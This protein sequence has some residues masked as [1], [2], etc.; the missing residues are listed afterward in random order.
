MEENV[1]KDFET[2]SEFPDKYLKVS[3]NS[4]YYFIKKSGENFVAKRSLDS[5][6][7]VN[8]FNKDKLLTKKSYYDVSTGS[9]ILKTVSIKD[10]DGNN[11]EFV[12]NKNNVDI[13]SLSSILNIN[14][15]G[16]YYLSKEDINTLV[17]YKE[18]SAKTYNLKPRKYYF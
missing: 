14:E 18:G 16:V 8:I 5:L 15:N 3:K 10:I 6:S 13:I 1:L 4:S 7:T 17:N 2:F 11:E 9:L 12:E